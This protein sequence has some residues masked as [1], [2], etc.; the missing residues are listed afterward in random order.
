MWRE[1]IRRD[2]LDEEVTTGPTAPTTVVT[3]VTTITTTIT[4]TGPTTITTATSNGSEF[5]AGCICVGQIID[6]RTTL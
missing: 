3:A 6:L 2:R 4:T 1:E 5:L